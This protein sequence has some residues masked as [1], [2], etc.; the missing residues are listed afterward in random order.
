MVG[1]TPPFLKN[2]ADIEQM[3]VYFTDIQFG[4][5]KEKSPLIIVGEKLGIELKNAFKDIDL[6]E[7]RT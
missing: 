5:G 4:S 7:V 3:G 6:E 1:S 2:L